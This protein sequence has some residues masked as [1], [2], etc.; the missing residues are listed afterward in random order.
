MLTRKPQDLTRNNCSVF[1]GGLKA[2][3]TEDVLIKYF[4]TFG[5]VESI[6]L[7]K[8]KKMKNI[9]RGFCIVKF[10]CAKIAER[11]IKM[12]DHFI[13]KRL[14]TCR[15]YLKGDQ[16]K[17]SKT[18]KNGRKIYISSLP[19]HTTNADIQQVFSKFGKVEAGYTLKEDGTGD[20]KGFGFVTFDEE[21]SVE[22]VFKEAKNI[23]IRGVKITVARFLAQ[24]GEEEEAVPKNTSFPKIFSAIGT[25]PKSGSQIENPCKLINKKMAKGLNKNS[26]IFKYE[27]PERK[28]NPRAFLEPRTQET[29]QMIFQQRRAVDKPWLSYRYD[30]QVPR[31]ALP[32]RALREDELERQGQGQIIEE[33][34]PRVASNEETPTKKQRLR[35]KEEFP[36]RIGPSHPSKV[37]KTLD[38]HQLLP[39]STAY[40]RSLGTKVSK[41]WHDINVSNLKLRLASPSY[42]SNCGIF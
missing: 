18:K 30:Y 9:N 23:E 27:Q 22:K 15:P 20:S 42:T 39:T 14:V 6:N 1:V 2:T 25:T 17:E 24:K 11:V 12:K 34:A 4:G 10:K 37:Q 33:A 3:F 13:K 38:E 16:L 8:N 26:S 21:S 31:F 29:S 19:R 41:S 35:T 28:V 32:Q 7:K 40:H 36:K 5:D